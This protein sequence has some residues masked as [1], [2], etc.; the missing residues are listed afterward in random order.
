MATIEHRDQN[1][2]VFTIAPD[3]PIS[4]AYDKGYTD[5][6]AA[7]GAEVARLRT[8]LAAMS[9]RERLFA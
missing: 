2:A 4:V 7:I 5:G 6:L 9:R 1:V 3:S 8:E